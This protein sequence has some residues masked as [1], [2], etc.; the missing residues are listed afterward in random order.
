MLDSDK[1]LAILLYSFHL[2]QFSQALRKAD[3]SGVTEMVAVVHV[4]LHAASISS[5]E[6]YVVHFCVP[7]CI[8][9][10]NSEL[11]CI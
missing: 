1:Y 4:H 5:A 11:F 9:C 3:A 7:I 8:I 10:M 2:I 6:H